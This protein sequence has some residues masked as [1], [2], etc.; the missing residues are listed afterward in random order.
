[1][2]K[3][4]AYTVRPPVPPSNRLADEAREQR[5]VALNALLSQAL[6]SGDNQEFQG[7]NRELKATVLSRSAGQLARMRLSAE[8]V[9]P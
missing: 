7:L 4:R 1:M 8:G 2:R 5:I 6:S 9:T 3:G